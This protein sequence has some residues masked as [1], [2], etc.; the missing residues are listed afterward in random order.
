MGPAPTHPGGVSTYNAKLAKSLAKYVE[1]QP[2]WIDPVIP[3]AFY[4][5]A[6][7]RTEPDATGESSLLRSAFTLN[8]FSLVSW[9]KLAKALRR[10][11]PDCAIVQ[12][13]SAAVAPIIVLG[14]LL[15][16]IRDM[17]V[18]LDMH[19][20]VD[21][22]EGRSFIVATMGKWSLKLLGS[23]SGFIVHADDQ[24]SAL[25][26]ILGK[27]T[28][29][30]R[31]VLHP[32]YSHYPRTGKL[33]ARTELGIERQHLVLAFGTIRHYKGLEFLLEAYESLPPQLRS[34]TN[35]AV[36][37]GTWRGESEAVLRRVSESAARDGIL[38][39]AEYVSDREAGLW[40]SAADLVVQPYLRGSQSGVTT[41]AMAYGLPCL[42][43]ATPIAQQLQAIYSGIYTT[44]MADA[45]TLTARIREILESREIRYKIPQGLDW[46][47]AAQEYVRLIIGDVE[48]NEELM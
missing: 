34:T 2:V 26:A 46:D 24:T 5:F 16:N 1:L 8:P 35:L 15:F 21:P 12:W 47:H 18:Y 37:G 40:F 33:E 43:T 4:P 30:V 23:R 9:F 42:V 48:N 29:A 36:V 19:E 10:S 32:L 25:R 45:Q 17:K 7:L 14:L 31:Q 27:K 20:T 41:I 13:W 38:L 11:Q 44:P 6:L 28:A 3:H 39:R 22:S